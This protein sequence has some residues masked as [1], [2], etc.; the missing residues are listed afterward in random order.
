MR[1]V[2]SNFC[3]N[4][5]LD[6]LAQKS[7]KTRTFIGTYTTISHDRFNFNGHSCANPGYQRSQEETAQH[8]EWAWR[9]DV[10]RI[11]FPNPVTI[12]EMSGCD[13]FLYPIRKDHLMIAD[14]GDFFEAV[15]VKG[16]TGKPASRTRP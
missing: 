10:S 11:P 3:P 1:R 8:F 12:I 16:T 15:R 4:F 2:N 7:F 14:R 6:S 13:S 9:A 5:N